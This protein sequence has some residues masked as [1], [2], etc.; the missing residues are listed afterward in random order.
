MRFRERVGRRMRARQLLFRPRVIPVFIFNDSIFQNEET[1]MINTTDALDLSADILDV[2]DIISRF[3]E[4]EADRK[5]TRLNS[6]HEWISR[7]PSSA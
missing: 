6:S 3:E 7:M 2:R 5:S 4:L 1:I